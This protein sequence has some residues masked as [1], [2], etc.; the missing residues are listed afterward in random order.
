MADI[1]RSDSVSIDTFSGMKA[2]VVSGLFAGENIDAGSPCYLKSD[3][4]VYMSV[5]TVVIGAKTNVL[6]FAPKAYKTGDPITVY[7]LG[8]RFDYGTDLTV[9]AFLYVSDTKGKLADSAVASNDLPV[10]VCVSKTD[11]VVIR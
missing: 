10:C 1:T 2:P 6:G 11:I 7:G 8:A 3:G 4:K 5:S 9:G